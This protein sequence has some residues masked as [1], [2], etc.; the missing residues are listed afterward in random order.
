MIPR[1]AVPADM[2]PLLDLWQARWFDAHGAISPPELLA[3]RTREDFRLRLAEFGDGI[4]VIGPEGAPQGFSAVKGDTI[5][6]LYVSREMA[7]TGAALILLR[8]AEVRIAA[9]G[10]AEARLDCNPGNARAAAFY[11][12]SGWRDRGLQRVMLDSATGRFPFD[13]LVFTRALA[14]PSPA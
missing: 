10:F 5:D 2:A 13:C 3:M 9:A 14:A 4:R 8:D 1:P 12:K 11:R 6:Q 7:G